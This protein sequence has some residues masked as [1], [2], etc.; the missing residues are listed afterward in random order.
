MQR[1]KTI[2][3]L[4]FVCCFLLLL[5][6]TPATAWAENETETD[7]S[8]QLQEEIGKLQDQEEAL[9]KKLDKLEGKKT[10]L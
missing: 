1:N 9:R 5:S 8:S 2:R 3:Y 4:A 10:T 7:S 6:W